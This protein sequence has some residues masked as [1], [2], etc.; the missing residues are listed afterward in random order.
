ME[1]VVPEK[2]EEQKLST[3]KDKAVISYRLKCSES[4]NGLSHYIMYG[5]LPE[6]DQP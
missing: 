3:K 1:K 6:E 4:G 5:D 2:E